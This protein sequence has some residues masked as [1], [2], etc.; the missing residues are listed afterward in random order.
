MCRVITSSYVD[1]EQLTFSS[2]FCSRHSPQEAEANFLALLFRLF[3]LL[4]LLFL[5]VFSFCLVLLFLLDFGFL[6]LLFLALLLHLVAH[7][8]TGR[9]TGGGVT[10]RAQV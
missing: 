3:R 1:L 8:L 5:F 10:A 7:T 6:F 9:T 4:R 2:R